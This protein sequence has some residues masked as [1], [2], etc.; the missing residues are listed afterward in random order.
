MLN[1]IWFIMIV[2][3]VLAALLL[4]RMSS[5]GAG[6]LADAEKS[7]NILLPQVGFLS[8]W[9]GIMRLVEKSG[10]IHFIS[11]ALSPVLG[12]LFPAVPKGHA[13]LG[14]IAM[15][16]GATMLGASNAATPAGLRAM[17]HL[18]TLNPHKHVAT[19]EMCMLLALC[20]AAITLIP[21]ST[22]RALHQLDSAR[23]TDIIL[24][25]ICTTILAT[26]VGVF[27][28]K[29]LQRRSVYVP[30][31][32]DAALEAEAEKQFQ[33]AAEKSPE[34]VPEVRP[35]EVWKKVLLGLV[36]LLPVLVGLGYVLVPEKLFGWHVSLANVLGTKLPPD[37]ALFSGLESS[38]PFS[39]FVKYFSAITIPL[40]MGYCVLHA[41]LARVKVFEEAVEGAKDGFFVV[42]RVIPYVAAILVGIRM[43]RESGLMGLIEQVLRPLTSLIGFPESV[44]PMAIIR[45]MSGGAAQGV[46]MDVAAAQGPNH[47]DTMIAATING[48]ADTTF[49]IV[50]VY[51]G[52]VGIK[53]IRHAL[54]AG[55]I[56]DIAVMIGAV[57]ICRALLS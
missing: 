38:T 2:G 54:A 30:G 57:W 4:G 33:S 5:V 6:V 47:M 18:Q 51:F 39:R 10:M 24:P 26:C 28:A 14:A 31:P 55:L 42:V 36:L 32:E 53:K 45:P 41:F 27:A 34:V 16:L 9:M 25:A 19:N 7:V 52:S 44:L 1:W 50:A 37:A 12:F 17:H 22:L 35:L 43:L 40:F 29:M 20:T 8:L 23:T 11:N 15:N 13:A 49:Y 3:S 46:L 21:G 56:A 48:S